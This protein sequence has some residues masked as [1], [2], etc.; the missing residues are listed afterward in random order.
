MHKLVI[1]LFYLYLKIYPI[2]TSSLSL[3]EIT[4]TDVGSN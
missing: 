1:N 2:G 4:R 3:A